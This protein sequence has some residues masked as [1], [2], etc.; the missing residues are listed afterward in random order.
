MKMETK[1]EKQQQDCL[2]LA[3]KWVTPSFLAQMLQ[4]YSIIQHTFIENPLCAKLI[5]LDT[6]T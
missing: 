3:E 2:F 5:I 1:K 4:I 6:L